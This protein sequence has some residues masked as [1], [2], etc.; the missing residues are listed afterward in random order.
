MNVTKA[1]EEKAKDDAHTKSKRAEEAD[2]EYQKFLAMAN[3]KQIKHYQEELPNAINAIQK[4]EELRVDHMKQVLVKYASSTL[5]YLPDITAAYQKIFE[6][7]ST[8]SKSDDS[9]LFIKQN[10]LNAT[11][12]PPIPYENYW[13]KYA[14][15]SQKKILVLKGAEED[16]KLESIAPEKAYKKALARL[17]ELDKEISEL[18]D[19]KSGI[20]LLADAYEATPELADPKALVDLGLQLDDLEQKIDIAK[21]KK[22]KYEGFVTKHEKKEQPKMPVLYADT[23]EGALAAQL[24]ALVLGEKAVQFNKSSLSLADS[25]KQAPMSSSDFDLNNADSVSADAKKFIALYDF[26]TSG[27]PNELGISKGDIIYVSDQPSE[28]GW[29]KARD[30]S[31]RIGYVPSTYIAEHSG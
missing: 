21:L 31:G 9:L 29:V 14:S 3:D 24:R 19:K 2:E 20:E 6:V 30:A 12:P 22:F 27:N 8:I 11:M 23:K 18:E 26:P 28:K 5:Q 1:N 25:S 17:K 10:R 4:M 15:K 7:A 16:D 13:E